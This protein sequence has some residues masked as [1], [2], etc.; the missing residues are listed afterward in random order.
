[1]K[2]FKNSF[3]YNHID[4]DGEVNSL[5][6]LTQ[7]EMTMSLKEL[8]NRYTR[9]GQVATFTPVYQDHEDFDDSPELEKMDAPEKLQYALDIKMGI[10]QKQRQMA[11][12]KLRKQEAQK[13]PP[14]EETKKE[15]KSNNTP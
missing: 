5:P 9:G 2:K 8:L 6:S 11:E 12:E 14:V 10:K 4:R 15:E 7:P 3:E 13:I 1:M